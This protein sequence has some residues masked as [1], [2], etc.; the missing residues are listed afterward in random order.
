MKLSF[1]TL[2]CPAWNMARIIEQ[3]RALGF[4][5]VELRGVAGEHL[6]PDETPQARADIK[7]AF[8][9]NG[10]NVSCIMGYSNFTKDD[11]KPDIEVISKFLAVAQDIGCPTLR[12]FGGV[13]QEIPRDE[14]IKRVVACLRQVAPIA[15]RHGVRLALE[16]HDDWCKAENIRA[17]IDAVNSP[18]VGVCWDIANAHFV[19]PMDVTFPLIK[20]RIVH[21]HF[22][23]AKRDA[24]GKVHSCLPGQGEVDMLGALKKLRSIDYRG[25]LSFEWEKKWEP[26][27]QDPEIAFPHF[28]KHAKLLLAKV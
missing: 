2:G 19:E 16:T 10:L 17:V 24:Q 4:D 14:A 1:A 23:D 21:V 5:G 12:F 6:S 13:N 20:D 8:A 11:P 3:A 26:S 9:D 25:Y 27:L 28:I 7:K 15:Q 18:N 22:K